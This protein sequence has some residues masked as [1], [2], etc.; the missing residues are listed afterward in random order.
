MKSVVLLISAA[1]A[2]TAY[3][4]KL[5]TIPFTG[6]DRKGLSASAWGP[7]RKKLGSLVD[8]PLENIDLAYLIDVEVGNKRYLNQNGNECR[9]LISNLP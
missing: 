6:V 1:I 3:A 5:V 2:T 7:G 9:S 8:V 4:S